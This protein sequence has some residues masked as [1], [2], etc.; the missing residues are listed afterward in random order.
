MEQRYLRADSSAMVNNAI[1]SILRCKILHKVP[2]TLL[3]TNEHNMWLQCKEPQ[4]QFL[5]LF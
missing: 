1:T 4:V 2:A 3:E 5:F